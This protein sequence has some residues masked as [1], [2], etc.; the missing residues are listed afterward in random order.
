MAKKD[1]GGGEIDPQIL[2]ALAHPLRV[3][4]LRLF[5]EG[6]SGPKR[7][8]DRIGEPLA[9]V[10]YHT[11]VLLDC[12]CIEP[13]ETIPCRGA[14]EHIYRLKPGKALGSFDWLSVPPSL[15]E[16]M[17]GSS[18]EA[19]TTRAVEALKAGSLQGR[20]D[21]RVT[22]LPLMVDEKG[23]KELVGIAERAENSFRA[24]AERS[25]ERL[26][27]SAEGFPVIV[28]V[29]TFESASGKAGS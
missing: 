19:F 23:W 10:A 13:V 16:G 7:L 26:K 1:E 8:A 14:V 20:E 2:R 21:S 3:R 25:A 24:A 5:E 17:A 15:R 27:G 18:L 28:A 4:I 6:P 9:N 12:G 11:N 22:W 29:A